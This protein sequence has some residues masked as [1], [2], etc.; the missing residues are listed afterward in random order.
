MA[1]KNAQSW[2]CSYCQQEFLGRRNFFQHLKVCEEKLKYPH[3]SLGRIISAEG[4]KKAGE[5]YKKNW[6]LGKH[7]KRIQHWSAESRAKQAEMMRKRHNCGNFCNYNESA[8]HFI[9]NLNKEK[10]WHLQ[11]AL[12]GG[13]VQVGP[14]FLDGYDKELNIAFEYDERKHENCKRKEHDIE[15]M[16]YIIEKLNCVFYRYSELFNKLYKYE[17]ERGILELE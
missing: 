11:H 10:G 16:N 5:S 1:Y 7:K 4:H 15:R 13:E 3:D 2:K 17:R 12:N 8:C 6:E 9:D 14:Y